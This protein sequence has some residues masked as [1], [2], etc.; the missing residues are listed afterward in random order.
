[1]D[2]ATVQDIRPDVA[3]FLAQV[4]A[5][6]AQPAPEEVG[7]AAMRAGMDGLAA[8]TDAPM[9][10]TLL[11]RDFTVP[12]D[13]GTPIALRLFDHRGDRDCGPAVLYFHGGGFVSG[14]LDSF[15]SICAEMAWI[16]DL[17]VL[18]VNYRLAPE[19]PWPAAPEDCE[20][21]ARATAAP[22]EVI[23]DC[24]G[25]VP[26]G[27]V[28]AGDSAGAWL[29]LVT[30]HA[31]QATPAAV[32]VI[33]CQLT[34]PWV[35]PGSTDTASHA[36]F[37]SGYMVTAELL[38]WFAQCFAVSPGHW[39]AQLLSADY[40]GFPPTAIMTAGLDPVRDQGRQLAGVLAAGG[41]TLISRE[42][43]GNVH[44]FLGLRGA[45]PS[46]A[47]DLTLAMTDLAHL[48]DRLRCS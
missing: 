44:A 12:A 3:A 22:D 43:V 14:S 27:L 26:T 40:A 24:L 5:S 16:L 21:A 23:G 6:P 31:L 20:A 48:L 2:S 46:S 4:N 11:V 39:H 9:R 47:G 42:A 34:Y 18:A 32:P 15:A 19:H 25:F 38:D 10:E 30:A 35:E 28:L 37:G 17:P 1:M 45:V 8:M 29:A 41:V 36:Q 13:D 33:A 7:A